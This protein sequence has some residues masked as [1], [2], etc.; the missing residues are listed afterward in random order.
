[1]QNGVIKLADFGIA[2]IVGYATVTLAGQ[3]AMTMAYAAPEVWDPDGPFGAPS[4]RSDLY[5]MGILLYQCLTGEPPFGGNYAAMYRAH[6]ERRPDLDIL[7]AGTPASLR[8]L[9]RRCLEKQQEN[10]PR[11]AAECYSLLCRA[12]AEVAEAAGEELNEP[13]H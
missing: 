7:P 3:T 12:Q 8:I 1:D 6:T 4:H 13:K 2:K 11:D 10:R 5:A 9:I